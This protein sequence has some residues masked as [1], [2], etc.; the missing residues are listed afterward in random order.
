MSSSGGV[1]TA[2]SADD[3]PVSTLFS[4]PVAGLIGGIWAGRT[5]GSPA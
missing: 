5:A 4:G 1:M 3:K 2:E